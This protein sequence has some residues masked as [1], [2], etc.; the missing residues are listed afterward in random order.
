M[1][2]WW[3]RVMAEKCPYCQASAGAYCITRNNWGTKRFHMDRV[4]LADSKS[5]MW[6]KWE[7]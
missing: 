2:T 6:E 4:R 3:E 5:N 7:K 1:K